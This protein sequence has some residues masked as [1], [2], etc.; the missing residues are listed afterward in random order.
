[1]IVLKFGGSS[2]ADIDEI[3][4]V[5]DIIRDRRERNP[6]V[7]VSAPG[8]ITDVLERLAFQSL[9][10]D[11]KIII[12]EFN[13][14]FE[15]R[16]Y[17]IIHGV[18]AR[19]LEQRECLTDVNRLLQELKNIYRGLT[20]IKELT[21]RALAT[22]LS[23]GEL[24]SQIMLTYALVSRDVPA[25][26]ISAVDC[27]ITD[28]HFARAAIDWTITANRLK[29]ILL[30]AIEDNK[31]PVIQGFIGGTE[32]GTVTT[33]GRGGSDYTAAIIGAV[34]A[35]EDIQIWTDVDGFLT[36][37]PAVIP[38][39]HTIPE[40]NIHEARELA[41]FGARILHPKT[42]LP[43]I[44]RQIPVFIKNTFAPENPGT[45]L[46]AGKGDDGIHGITVLRDLQMITV[47]WNRSEQKNLRSVTRRVDQSEVYFSFST[48]TSYSMISTERDPNDLRSRFSD[49]TEVTIQKDLSLI[50]LIGEHLTTQSPQ[51]Q[52]M[53]GLLADYTYE[54]F[55][56]SPMRNRWLL[57]VKKFEVD[58]I[59]Q[60]LY[61]EI[62]NRER[63]QA[64]T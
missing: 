37:D 36:A 20:L 35:A 27:L 61:Y 57:L 12:D 30:P 52:E 50:A 11:E 42:V 8:D 54:L 38:E 9:E 10:N 2:L 41:Q 17:R 51:Y 53:M 39:A 47:E 64:R 26:R 25:V 4:R 24:F 28:D 44:N 63:E 1:M 31:I 48:S 49:D 14:Y 46:S 43:A 16:L 7:V 3:R 21:P 22:L 15:P 40:L 32:D 55:S 56:A 29:E 13:N 19:N 62:F 45:L 6:A 18:I 58:E 5:I 34:C 23:Y 59:V 33:L 60:K